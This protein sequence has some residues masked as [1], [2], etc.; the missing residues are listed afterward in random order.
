[1]LKRLRNLE[2]IRANK[3]EIYPSLALGA[4]GIVLP[5][6]AMPV[7]LE[8]LA[9]SLVLCLIAGVC[10]FNASGDEKMGIVGRTF[11]LAWLAL[12]GAQV[13]FSVLG[14]IGMPDGPRA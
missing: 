5:S 13:I 9:V 8:A 12:L 6:L 14:M 1:M 4:I 10:A 7:K 3:Y 2:V 11:C